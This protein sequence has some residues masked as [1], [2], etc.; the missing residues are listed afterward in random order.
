MDKWQEL[1]EHIREFFRA[2]VLAI[3]LGLVAYCAG[4]AMAHDQ[5]IEWWGP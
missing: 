5:N 4:H 3:S 1:S 2:L